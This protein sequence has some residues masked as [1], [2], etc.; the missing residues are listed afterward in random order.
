MFA[1]YLLNQIAS[2]LMMT[3]FIVPVRTDALSVRRKALKKRKMDIG[4]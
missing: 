2:I 4:I 3:A 1:N